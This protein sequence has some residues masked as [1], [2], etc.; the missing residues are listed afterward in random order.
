MQYQQSAWVSFRHPKFCRRLRSEDTPRRLDVQRGSETTPP[1]VGANRRT[2]SQ[3]CRRTATPPW[4]CTPLDAVSTFD[5][6]T[7]LDRR[8]PS[9]A[10]NGC[11]RHASR[12]LTGKELPLTVEAALR[13]GTEVGL[14]FPLITPVPAQPFVVRLSQLTIGNCALWRDKRFFDTSSRW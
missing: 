6:R 9:I 10:L 14:E 4:S 12:S 11:A 13:L 5:H 7:G 8:W 1:T 2:I 3:Q